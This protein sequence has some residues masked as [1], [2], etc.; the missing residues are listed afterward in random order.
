MPLP[1]V[2]NILEEGVESLWE[3]AVR[4]ESRETI[5]PGRY[6]KSQRLWH[7]SCTE[8]SQSTVQHG[9]AGPARRGRV[10]RGGGGSSVERAGP[11]W[12]GQ[13]SQ[14]LLHLEEVVVESDPDL[15][16]GE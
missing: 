5:S 7:K 9:G 11:A 14:A 15:V 6:R 2:Q 8:S 1:Q 12:S 16:G 4:E 10:Q 3:P 13:G